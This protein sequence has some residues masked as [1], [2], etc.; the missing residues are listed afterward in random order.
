MHIYLQLVTL[1]TYC[2]SRQVS[3]LKVRAMFKELLDGEGWELLFQF[4]P[5]GGVLGSLLHLLRLPVIDP[6]AAHLDSV[7]SLLLM[8]NHPH[9]HSI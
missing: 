3:T 1:I 6:R 4:P 7:D 2:P 8:I 5:K 9:I